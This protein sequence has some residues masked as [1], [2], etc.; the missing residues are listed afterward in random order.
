MQEEKVETP[1]T[2]FESPAVLKSM[3]SYSGKS[4]KSMTSGHK[5]DEIIG[6]LFD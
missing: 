3:R 6:N 5:E 1:T 2:T 4:G